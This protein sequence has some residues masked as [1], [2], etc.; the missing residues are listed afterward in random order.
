MRLSQSS[1]STV[2]SIPVNLRCQT[3]HF[4]QGAAYAFYAERNN[5]KRIG[6]YTIHYEDGRTQEIPVLVGKHVRDWFYY[7]TPAVEA[8]EA[9]MVWVGLSSRTRDIAGTFMRLYK[10]CWTNPFPELQVKSIDFGADGSFGIPFLIALTTQMEGLPAPA[11]RPAVT[12]QEDAV[13]AQT[14]ECAKGSSNCLWRDGERLV[15]RS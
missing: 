12:S 7:E 15:V 10:M 14:L 2:T 9:P 6:K 3:L 8:S 13:I 1:P 4:L 5:D 11:S